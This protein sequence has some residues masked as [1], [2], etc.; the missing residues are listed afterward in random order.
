MAGRKRK[1][2]R[3]QLLVDF[4]AYIERTP[5]PIACEFAAARGIPKSTLYSWEE[6]AEALEL[7]TTKKEAALERGMLSGDFPPAG[8]IFSLKQLGWT[9]RQQLTHGGE[10]RLT[11][12]EERA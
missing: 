3:R 9:D 11:S 7:A 4:A 6:F 10:V 1:W 2:N 8:A 12:A 5:L